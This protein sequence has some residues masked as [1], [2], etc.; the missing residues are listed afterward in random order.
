MLILFACR[1][2]GIRLSTPLSVGI[3]SLALPLVLWIPD[4]RIV[5]VSLGCETFLLVTLSQLLSAIRYECRAA[6]SAARE[7]LQY[8]LP[9][10]AKDSPLR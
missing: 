6:A 2:Q 8:G 10:T 5:L 4:R 7:V 3:S 1:E 9:P